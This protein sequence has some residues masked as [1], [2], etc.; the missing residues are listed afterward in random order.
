MT[1]NWA[2]PFIKT[3][4]KSRLYKRPSLSTYASPPNWAN[5]TEG[6][7]CAGKMEIISPKPSFYKRE[8]MSPTGLTHRASQCQCLFISRFCALPKDSPEC[9]A[10]HLAFDG[11]NYSTQSEWWCCGAAFN[12]DS[13]FQ[14]LLGL[15]SFPVCKGTWSYTRPSQQACTLSVCER[16]LPPNMGRKSRRPPN[17]TTTLLTPFVKEK[18]INIFL[19]PKHSSP[20]RPIWL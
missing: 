19:D 14:L 9:E 17:K 4:A 1:W 6:W 5:L 20:R 16:P 15:L 13:N 3:V 10:S 8:K 12:P 18:R 11:S 2:G 7:A